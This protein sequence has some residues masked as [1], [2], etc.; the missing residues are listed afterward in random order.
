MARDGP[1]E[2]DRGAR[3]GA[4]VDVGVAPRRLDQVDDVAADRGRHVD[5]SRLLDHLR[6]ARRVGDRADVVEGRP[7]AVGR[8]DLG[9]DL[10]RRGSRSTG[11]A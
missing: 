11:A 9:L 7:G 1:Q 3:A 8:E 6:D 10:G 2:H 5:L 4:E